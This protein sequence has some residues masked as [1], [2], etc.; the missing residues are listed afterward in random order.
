MRRMCRRNDAWGRRSAR[1]DTYSR[2][3]SFLCG[4]SSRGVP[5]TL[6]QRNAQRSTI[7]IWIGKAV[8]QVGRVA[9]GPITGHATSIIMQ[10]ASAIARS[11]LTNV[12]YTADADESLPP[13]SSAR[14]LKRV[15]PLV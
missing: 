13:A 2:C 1:T 6:P 11:W 14:S 3:F 12:Y 8:L 9:H 4:S 5:C 15:R 10:C 7:S